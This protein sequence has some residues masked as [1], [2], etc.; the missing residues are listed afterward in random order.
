MFPIPHNYSGIET[1]LLDLADNPELEYKYTNWGE[2]REKTILENK[3][4]YETQADYGDVKLDDPKTQWE[5]TYMHGLDKQGNRYENHIT[6]RNF[7]KFEDK[8]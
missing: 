8:K 2:I 7:P 6:S 4:A 3:I 5:A 1:E